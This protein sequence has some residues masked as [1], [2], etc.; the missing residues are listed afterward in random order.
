MAKFLN[1]RQRRTDWRLL[2]PTK[3]D[4]TRYD[5]ENGGDK[6]AKHQKPKEEEI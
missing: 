5:A 1:L 2:L 6:K 4:T 3:K